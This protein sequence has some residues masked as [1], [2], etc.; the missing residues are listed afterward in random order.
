MRLRSPTSGFYFIKCQKVQRFMLILIKHVSTATVVTTGKL[1]DTETAC[2]Q[3]RLL[4]SPQL[5]NSLLRFPSETLRFAP[6][7]EEPVITGSTVMKSLSPSAPTLV[8]VLRWGC[9]CARDRL[10]NVLSS[11]LAL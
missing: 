6:C 3:T 8:A 7:T 9:Y 11:S 2:F 5:R 4:M 1:V 10:L